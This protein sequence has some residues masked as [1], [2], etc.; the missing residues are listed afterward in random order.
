MSVKDRVVFPMVPEP[1]RTLAIAAHDALH[2]LWSRAP[3]DTSYDKKAWQ[4]LEGAIS[5]LARD[6]EKR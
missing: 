4:R 1:R 5:D 2:T 6:G 3:R